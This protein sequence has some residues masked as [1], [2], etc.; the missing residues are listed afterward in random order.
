M[1]AGPSEAWYL[2]DVGSGFVLAAEDAQ[3][4]HCF[5]LLRCVCQANLGN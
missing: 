2:G 4:H 1:V 3:I 5:I